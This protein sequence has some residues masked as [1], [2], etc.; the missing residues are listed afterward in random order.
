LRAQDF[1]VDERKRQQRCRA[2]KRGTATEPPA[3]CHAPPSA[4]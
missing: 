1:R 4:C 3:P 2:R